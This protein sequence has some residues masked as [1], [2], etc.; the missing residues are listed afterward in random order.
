MLSANSKNESFELIPR[1]IRLARGAYW[2]IKLRWIAIVIV[3]WSIIMAKNVFDIHVQVFPLYLSVLGLIIENIVLILVLNYFDKK[4]KLESINLLKMVINFQM[5]YDLFFLVA[6]LHFTGG[7]ENPFYLFFIFHMVI[8][9]N[10]LSKK[11]CFLIV[12]Y[13]LI[14]LCLMTIL[15]YYGLIKHYNL[16]LKNSLNSSLYKDPYF[17]FE[18][19]TIFIIT[20]YLL[21]YI[22]NTIISLLRQQERALQHANK[23]LLEKD[24]IKNEYVLRLTHDIKGHLTAIQTNIALFSN[25]LLGTLNEKQKE[26]IDNTYNRVIKLSAFVNKLLNLTYMRL[27]NSI[28]IETFSIHEAVRTAV[29]SVNNIAESKKISIYFNVD[30]TLDKISNNQFSFEELISSMLLN[31]IK[32]TSDSGKIDLLVK[33]KENN[34]LIEISDNGIGIPENEVSRIFDEFYR[35]SNAKK[36]V[37]DGTGLGLA[38]VKQIVG[39]YHGNIRVESKENIGTTFYVT[40]PK[41]I[42]PHLFSTHLHDTI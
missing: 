25:N 26:F 3:I 12:T 8:S 22:A 21:V 11:N 41:D 32:Y 39:L 17:I 35:A 1:N 31:S 24:E 23:K 13:A 36:S 2:L 6:F 9:S 4:N 7:I 14:L 16:W 10:L 30:V 29:S 15:E 38:M 5:L 33:D 18:T 27:N 42:S 20:S 37:K 40:F 28:E 19:L 34:I